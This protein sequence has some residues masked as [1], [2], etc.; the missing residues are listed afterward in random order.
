MY[1]QAVPSLELSM[2]N[3]RAQFATLISDFHLNVSA[4]REGKCASVRITSK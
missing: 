1:C 4:E 3:R 2:R